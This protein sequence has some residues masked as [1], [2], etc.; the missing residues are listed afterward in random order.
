MNDHQNNHQ[1]D[2]VQLVTQYGKAMLRVGQ[3]EQ[4]VSALEAQL[5]RVDPPR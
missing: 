2:F 5:E 4:Q 1:I 3:L